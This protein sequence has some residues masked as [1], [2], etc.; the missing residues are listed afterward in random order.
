M[1]G[2]VRKDDDHGKGR[3]VLAM[4]DGQ[5]AQL[6]FVPGGPGQVL[7]HLAVAGPAQRHDPHHVARVIPHQHDPGRR[8]RDIGPSADRNADVSLGKCGCVVHAVANHRDLAALPL[9]LLDL[10]GLVLRQHLRKNRGDA[11][12]AG[13]GGGGTRVVAG[14]H[15]RGQAHL[16]Q[17]RQGRHRIRFDGV[18]NRQN[19]GG[20]PVDRGEDGRLTFGCVPV[21]NL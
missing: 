4:P 12:L 3:Y 9:Q 17:R 8:P 21:G 15:H 13:D 11:D 6:T 18:G 19:A 7:H 1:D 2:E 14:D 20:L 10:G 5:E 16:V